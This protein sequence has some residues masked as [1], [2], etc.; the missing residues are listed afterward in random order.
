M[1]L[2]GP[3]NKRF[4]LIIL[5]LLKNN[6][7]FLGNLVF[8]YRITRWLGKYILIKMQIVDVVLENILERQWKLRFRK[9]FSKEG[10]FSEQ[11]SISSDNKNNIIS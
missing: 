10:S 2:R 4:V 11:E 8:V 9:Q 7:Y 5:S 1:A 6:E 3:C